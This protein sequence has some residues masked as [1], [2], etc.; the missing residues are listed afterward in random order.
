MD[1]ILAGKLQGRNRGNGQD[2]LVSAEIF[3]VSSTPARDLERKATEG[4]RKR[5]DPLPPLAMGGPRLACQG[6]A[7]RAASGGTWIM[8][9][10]LI[11]RD[12]VRRCRKEHGS[13]PRGVRAIP[14]GVP[15]SPLESRVQEVLAAHP[16]CRWDHLVDEV[17]QHLRRSERPSVLAV[18]DEGFWGGWV[19]PALAREELRRLEGI[20]LAIEGPSPVTA[21]IPLPVSGR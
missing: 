2:L 13:G 5:D 19:W 4:A 9:R 3:E 21:D 14:G 17:A 15:R 12:Y 1:G 18:L 8:R 7:E 6:G 16:T 10:F 11:L 20:L